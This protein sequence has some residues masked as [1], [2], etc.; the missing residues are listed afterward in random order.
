MK[1]T[2]KYYLAFLVTPI[3]LLVL[4]FPVYANKNDIHLRMLV[5]PTPDQVPQIPNYLGNYNLESHDKFKSLINELG[6]VFSPKFLAPATTLGL[7]GFAVGMSFSFNNINNTADYWQ[8]TE[9]VFSNK[10]PSSVLTTMQMSMRKGLPLSFE[11]ET[12]FTNLL[13]SNMYAVGGSL[14]WSLNEGFYMIPDFAVRGSIN[15]L[16]SSRDIMLTTAGFDLTASKQWSFLGIISI[17]PYAGYN[18]LGVDAYSKLIAPTPERSDDGNEE[19]PDTEEK[20][21]EDWKADK[22]AGDFVFRRESMGNNLH[23]RAFVGLM[24]KVLFVSLTMDGSFSSNSM[25]AYNVKLAFDF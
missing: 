15:T 3:L 16:M 18:L 8:V 9:S 21:D 7:N 23:Q 17:A 25:R 13:Y 24:F 14:K 4:T 5:R 10:K 1:S 11:V 6:M 22:K 20:W 19:M 12:T 2:V